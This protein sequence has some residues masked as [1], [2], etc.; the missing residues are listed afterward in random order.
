MITNKKAALFFLVSNTL[1]ICTH[2]F[3]YFYLND[4]I[5]ESLDT[6][7]SGHVKYWQ[8]IS[9][10]ETILWFTE[11]VGLIWILSLFNEKWWIRTTIILFIISQSAVLVFGLFV[12]HIHIRVQIFFTLFA[13]TNFGIMIYMLIAFIRVREKSIRPYLIWY[14]VLVFSAVILPPLGRIFYDSLGFW[15]LLISRNF[16]VKLPS[17]TALII[18]VEVYNTASKKT[19]AEQ[20]SAS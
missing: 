12:D 20:L 6:A 14:I 16:L 3:I 15:W 1:L 9:G 13:Y 19:A 18:F 11:K 10:F 17:I 8:L 4:R 2:I 7:P 5:F